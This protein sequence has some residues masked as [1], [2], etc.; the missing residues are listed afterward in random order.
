MFN[1]LNICVI[2][3]LVAS[4]TACGHKDDSNASNPSPASST[5]VSTAA[6]APSTD[7]S[8]LPTN[9]TE[10]TAS[11]ATTQVTDS[12]GLISAVAPTAVPIPTIQVTTPS[13]PFI[14]TKSFNF[15]GGEQTAT[16]IT[17]KKDRTVILKEFSGGESMNL[18]FAVTYK[19]KFTNPLPLDKTGDIFALFKDGKVLRYIHGQLDTSCSD[20]QA[21][22]DNIPCV[23]ELDSI[24]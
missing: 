18:K 14:G 10:G 15:D 16:L 8:D 17:I 24:N 5:A 4:I 7:I 12:T 11:A 9:N 22:K 3:V 6:I 13:L 1:T 21:N 19:G 2:A 20:I 23:S